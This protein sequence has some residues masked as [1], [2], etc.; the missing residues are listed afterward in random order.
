MTMLYKISLRIASIL[1]FIHAAFH[2]LGTSQ[3]PTNPE[4]IALIEA[5]SRFQMDVMGSVRSYMDFFSGM[6]VFET[7]MFVGL[8]VLLWQLSNM[9]SEAKRAARPL[10]AT[11]AIIFLVFTAISI[12]YFFVVPVAME[13]LIAVLVAAAFFASGRHVA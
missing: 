1:C 8:S 7:A 4:E 3:V 2:Q 12:K 6:G 9:Q 5:M 10:L 11:L 13:A